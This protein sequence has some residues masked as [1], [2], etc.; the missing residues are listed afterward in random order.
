MLEEDWG[1]SEHGPDVYEDDTE[2]E[3]HPTWWD[4]LREFLGV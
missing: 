4:K 3:Y 2:Y 1:V